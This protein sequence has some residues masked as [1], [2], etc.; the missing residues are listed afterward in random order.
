MIME[1]AAIV[2]AIGRAVGLIFNRGTP[3][4]RLLKE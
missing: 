1:D 2:I 3:I 4:G